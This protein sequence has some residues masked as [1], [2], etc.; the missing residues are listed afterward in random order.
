MLSDVHGNASA[1]NAVL[2]DGKSYDIDQWWALGDLVLFGPDPIEVIEILRGLPRVRFVRGNTDRYVSLGPEAVAQAAGPAGLAAAD[3]HLQM[4][5]GSI[6]WTNR[7]LT[8]S[9]MVDWLER[10][11]AQLRVETPS[12][13]RLLGVH[14][15]LHSDDGPGIDPDIADEDL[16]PL[17]LGCHADV[18]V[19][20]HTHL[21]TDRFVNGLRALNPGSTGLPRRSEGA[22]WLL[23]DDDGDGLNV[24]HRVVGF[25]TESVVSRLDRQEHPARQFVEAVLARRHPFAL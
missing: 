20:G 2:A 18:V 19:G 8:E 17:L 15:S 5:V 16:H 25:D 11:P 24:E 23:I 3:Q 7:V 10:L 14:A 4:V 6:E 21:A 1:L 22:G 13:A 9:G 12:G